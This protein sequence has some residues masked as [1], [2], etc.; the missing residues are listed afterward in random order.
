MADLP[1]FTTTLSTWTIKSRTFTVQ[2]RR[3]LP[4]STTPKSSSAI[5]RS[6]QEAISYRTFQTCKARLIHNVHR[7]TYM[8]WAKN[9]SSRLK[10]TRCSWKSCRAKWSKKLWPINLQ[11]K[12]ISVIVIIQFKAT[13]RAQTGRSRTTCDFTSIRTKHQPKK[14]ITAT[15][16]HGIKHLLWIQQI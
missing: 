12:V 13:V 16:M 8:N 9:G 1:L 5:T 10:A 3:N 2:C 15:Q 4:N 7:V 11:N 14:S 6:F